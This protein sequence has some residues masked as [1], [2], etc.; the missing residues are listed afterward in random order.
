MNLEDWP[1]KVLQI[2]TLMILTTI[3]QEDKRKET[4]V[5]VVV[6]LL[7]IGGGGG[8]GAPGEERLIEAGLAGT[9]LACNV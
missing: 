2:V 5:R 7:W 3:E 8:G 4:E 9:L 1:D 6:D